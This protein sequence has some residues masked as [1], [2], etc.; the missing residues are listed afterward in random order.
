MLNRI[1]FVDFDLVNM[2]QGIIIPKVRPIDVAHYKS[3]LDVIKKHFNYPPFHTGLIVHFTMFCISH[4]SDEEKAELLDPE[5]IQ[6]LEE[7]SKEMIQHGISSSGNDFGTIY[8]PQLAKTLREMVKLKENTTI[9]LFSKEEARCTVVGESKWLDEKIDLFFGDIS[10]NIKPDHLT[11]ER[12][13][14]H[15]LGAGHLRSQCLTDFFNINSQRYIQLFRKGFGIS[16][17]KISR[18]AMDFCSLIVGLRSDNSKH[19]VDCIK[20]YTGIDN[21]GH[22]EHLYKSVPNKQLMHDE[23]FCKYL[24]PHHVARA[25]TL[26]LNIGKFVERKDIFFLT[27]MI[28]LLREDE[29]AG[30]RDSF[31]RLLM[32]RLNDCLVIR[33]V[34][35]VKVMFDQFCNDLVE[36]ARIAPEII[37]DAYATAA[38]ITEEANALVSCHSLS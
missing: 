5:K 34:C 6:S 38:N 7:L 35:D 30:W 10:N 19:L 12:L 9:S 14:A 21:L 28:F 15:Q 25:R 23:A 24:D 20:G 22:F 31:R 32:K 4:W 29:Y 37:Q 26:S 8:L 11:V 16:N 17:I 1:S 33:G 18:G 13:I 27:L 2:D 36:F 3:C